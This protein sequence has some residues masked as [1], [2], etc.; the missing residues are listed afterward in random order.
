MGLILSISLCS[1]NPNAKEK[2]GDQIEGHWEGIVS[3]SGIQ[4]NIFMDFFVDGNIRATISMPE[5]D[6]KFIPVDNLVFEP[7][8]LHFELKGSNN[9]VQIFEGFLEKNN[10][11]GTLTEG[12]YI[13]DVTLKR[14][15]RK[16]ER[17]EEYP[18]Y[19]ASKFRQYINIHRNQAVIEISKVFELYNIAIAITDYGLAKFINRKDQYCQDVLKH[20]LPFKKHALISK[21]EFSQEKFYEYL[22]LRT[23][24][25]FYDMKNGRLLKKDFLPATNFNDEMVHLIESFAKETDFE[26]FYRQ[27]ES[28][29]Q[30]QIESYQGM[31]PVT[32]MWL[33]L[34]NQFSIKYD[35]YIIII[36]P[37][38]VEANNTKR[39]DLEGSKLCLMFVSSPNSGNGVNKAL[40]EAGMSR[41]VFTEINH[42]YVNPIT[43]LYLTQVNEALV[44]LSQWNDDQ[45][46]KNVYNSA[47][48][49]IN[50][51]L[52]WAVYLLYAYDYYDNLTFKDIVNRV[53]RQM[54]KSR[55][56]VRFSSFSEFCLEL[57]RNKPN[58]KKISDL[59][60]E[61]I[62]WFRV[63]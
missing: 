33:W 45:K 52:T 55:G 13:L 54:D 8:R 47:Y 38:T 18:G 49:T 32:K 26:L 25:F 16:P 5:Q 35:S 39:I 46:T 3:F 11:R 60:P 29:Y 53:N 21:V 12:G 19:S 2:I 31:V 9:D 34:E 24:S 1:S 15:H 58:D 23:T 63:Q 22:N 28:Y 62:Q 7:P 59:F 51:Y 43:D 48:A 20:F 6:I 30:Q 40:T 14:I 10:I 27:H 50:E 61:M 36:S 17:G 44:D 57:Y 41:A 56:F 42:N 37:L 4:R